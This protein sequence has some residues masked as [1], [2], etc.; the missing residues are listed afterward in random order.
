[1]LDACE[2]R[3]EE[4]LLRAGQAESLAQ[5]ERRR[6]REDV[7]ALQSQLEEIGAGADGDAEKRVEEAREVAK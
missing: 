2:T 3:A 6:R 7:Q 5:R 4:A 1:M